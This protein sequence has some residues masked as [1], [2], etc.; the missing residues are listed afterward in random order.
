MHVFEG[1]L[2]RKMAFLC[3]IVIMYCNVHLVLSCIVHVYN[4]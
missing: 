3:Y 4:G 1:L 2:V